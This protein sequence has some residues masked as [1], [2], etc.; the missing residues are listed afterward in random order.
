MT[1][2]H[3]FDPARIAIFSLKG[4]GVLMY[5]PLLEAERLEHIKPFIDRHGVTFYP[6]ENS[7]FN[8]RYMG[9]C[10]EGA[11]AHASEHKLVYVEGLLGGVGLDGTQLWMVHA[12]CA[13]QSGVVV[14]PTRASIKGKFQYVGVP[15]RRSMAVAW[16]HSMGWY[17]LI[18]GHPIHGPVLPTMQPDL[19]R[20]YSL[21]LTA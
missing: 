10:F 8:P 5:D 18:D 17:G 12:W 20:D 6:P 14:D 15:I 11:L 4:G 21:H 16:H 3:T 19:Y 7:Q 1:Y 13:T 9:R 2:K